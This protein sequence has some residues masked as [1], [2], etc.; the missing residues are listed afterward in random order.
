MFFI[1]GIRIITGER[2]H[3]ASIFSIKNNVFGYLRYEPVI[4]ATWEDETRRTVVQCQ[5]GKIVHKTPSPKQPE[6]NRLEVWLN[7]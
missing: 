7:W 3:F 4:L 1:A 5:P 2:N 6:Q